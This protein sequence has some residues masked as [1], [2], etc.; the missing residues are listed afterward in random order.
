MVHQSSLSIANDDMQRVVRM[1]PEVFYMDVIS[2]TIRQKGDLFV[3]VVK[4][5][6][7]EQ[8]SVTPPCCPV[9]KIDDFG[10][11]PTFSLLPVWRHYTFLGE[12]GVD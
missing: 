7:G 10:G 5:V 9:A 3:L 8:T 11:L 4:D 6:S 12:I 2:N 1:F